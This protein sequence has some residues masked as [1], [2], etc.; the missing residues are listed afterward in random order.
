LAG[1]ID[2]LESKIS[3][4]K[5]EIRGVTLERESTERQLKYINE[6][7]ADLQALLEKQLVQKSRIMQLEREKAR[8]EGVIGRSTADQAKA[9]NGIGEANL[10]IRQTR[11]KFLEEVAGQILEVRGKIADLREKLR[12]ATDVLGRVDLTSP[13]SGTLQ[14]LKVFTVGGVIKA[15]EPLVEVVP[16]H[17]ELIVQAHVSP[18]D[19]ER[20]QVGMLA[21]VRFTAFLTNLLPLINGKVTTVSRDRLLDD[22]TK[23]PYFLA[24]VVAEDVPDAVR[25]RL[26]AGMPADIVIPTGERTI[27]N[28]LVRPLKDRLRGAL[29]ER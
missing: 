7:L 4:Y 23:Q 20:L 8:L 6:E 13:V 27:L 18:H 25:E 12:V 16:D 11:Q 15:G 14:N 3:Q 9:E 19:M 5:T 29:R 26:T 10:Q 1:Q 2:L 17:D 21:E 28:Y 22:V 24:Q